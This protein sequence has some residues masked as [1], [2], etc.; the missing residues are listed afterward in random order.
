VPG[1]TSAASWR[2]LR[3]HVPTCGARQL[4]ELHAA[5]KWLWPALVARLIAEGWNVETA[6]GH[7]GRLKDA[8]EP[9]AWTD[10]D[11]LARDIVAG[12]AH[13]NERSRA[14]TASRDARRRRFLAC[15]ALDPLPTGSLRRAT[16]ADDPAGEIEEIHALCDKILRLMRK[17]RSLTA[18]AADVGGPRMPQAQS[19]GRQ[20]DLEHQLDRLERWVEQLEARAAERRS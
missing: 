3:Q 2:R 13:S 17:S 4:A 18:T 15:A 5:N 12:K 6:R 19:H 11:A 7:A 9:P 8:P 14:S 20:L 10:R 16:M 1:S